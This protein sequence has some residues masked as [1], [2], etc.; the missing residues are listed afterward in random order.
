MKDMQKLLRKGIQYLK[1]YIPGKPV[2]EVQAELGPTEIVKLASN[3]NPLDPPAGVLAAMEKELRN[4]NRYPEGSCTLLR[5]EM[6]RRLGVGQDMLTVSNGADNCIRMAANAFINDGDEVLMADPTFSVY[7]TATRIM[8]GRPVRVPLKDDTHDLEAMAEKI[9]PKTK[10][11]FVCN[12][13]NP[14]G[15][16]VRK[17]ALDG[18]VAQLPANVILILDEAYFEFVSDPDY[19][20]GLDYIRQGCKV[21]CLRSFSKIYGI[22][23]LRIG[24]ALGCMEFIEALNRVREPFPVSRIAQAGALAVLEEAGFK[25]EVLNVNTEGRRYL[26]A[27]FSKL[28]LTYAPSFTNFVLVDLKRDSATVFQ[29]LLR[30]GVIIRPGHIWERSTWARVTIGARKENQKFIAALK[31]I[32]ANE[33]GAAG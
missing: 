29:A 6:S 11:V 24:Y 23:G 30:E 9:G 13:N 16:I 21:I 20:N 32:L 5:R 33:A 10:L 3:E 15:T 27:E 1:P 28:G 8:G 17:R 31:R 7:E 25:E 4:I 14:T 18:F 22:A 12:P 2:E 19:P 26:C